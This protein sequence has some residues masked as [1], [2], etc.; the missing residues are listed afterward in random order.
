M[1]QL[2]VLTKSNCYTDSIEDCIYE[3]AE[4]MVL[5][6]LSDYIDNFEVKDESS[7]L[8]GMP[9]DVVRQEL[10]ELTARSV[11]YVVASRCGLKADDVSFE[12]ISHFNSLPMFVS[13]G[14]SIMSIARAI[15]REINSEMYRCQ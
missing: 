2:P 11:Y 12:N 10:L 15:L 4:Q 8:Y 1:V 14:N 5:E 3:I 7:V 6:N 9:I 13:L